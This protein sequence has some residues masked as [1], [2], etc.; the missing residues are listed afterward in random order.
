MLG[1]PVLL[2]RLRHSI[3]TATVGLMPCGLCPGEATLS[4]SCSDKLAKWVLLGC[5]GSLLSNF[6]AQPLFID[7]ITIASPPGVRDDEG[8]A[9]CL[10]ALHRAVQGLPML[11]IDLLVT[12]STCSWDLGV[13]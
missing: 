13:Q 7:S 2:L 1:R 11:S 4:V 3:Q 5:Q 8:K 9:A 6:L 12:M 10:Q